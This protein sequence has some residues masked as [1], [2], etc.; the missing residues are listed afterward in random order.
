[1]SLDLISVAFVILGLGNVESPW[2][3]G[4]IVALVVTLSVFLVG[5]TVHLQQTSTR[6]VSESRWQ[7]LKE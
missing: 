1:M 3:E 7:D 5:A 2:S 6:Y 4:T